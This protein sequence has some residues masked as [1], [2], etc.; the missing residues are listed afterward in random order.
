MSVF[1][2][3]IMRLAADARKSKLKSVKV[4]LHATPGN[5]TTV[6]IPSFARGVLLYPSAEV[7]FA[8]DEDPAAEATSAD[9]AVAEAAMAVGGYLPAA[10]WSA[11]TLEEYN[12]AAKELR[13][14]GAAGSETV[15]VEFF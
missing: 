7:R 9:A 4:T 3:Y 6:A 12:G 14:I 10:E 15:V 2:T 8:V 13:L 1:D 11:R 5:V